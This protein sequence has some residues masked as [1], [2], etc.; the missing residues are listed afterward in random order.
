MAEICQSSN[1]LR[2]DVRPSRQKA[3]FHGWRVRPMARME[4]RYE[5]RL[6]TC[7]FSAARWIAA[8]GA[9]FEFHLQERARALAAGRQ[10]RRF[11]VD[12]FSRR[13]QQRRVIYATLAR[14]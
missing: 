3:A 1:V 10:L 4:P 13:R 6:A 5:S 12:R 8:V 7:R 14:R 11:R 2:V 9:A